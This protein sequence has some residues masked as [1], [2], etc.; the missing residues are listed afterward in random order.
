MKAG[1]IIGGAVLLIAGIALIVFAL[2][3]G[4]TVFHFGTG[5][6]V[7]STYT[8][9]EEYDSILVSTDVTDIVFAKSEDGKTTVV[10][11]EREHAR[12]SVKI[13]NGTLK[14]IREFENDSLPWTGLWN[15]TMKVTV[16]LPGESFESLKISAA[17]G[18][19]TVPDGFAFKSAEI[20]LST[21]DTV[22]NSDVAGTLKI[23]ASTG[24]VSLD[25]VSAGDVSLTVTTGKAVCSDLRAAGDLSVSVSTGKAEL[26]GVRC[27]RN[28][29]STGGTGKIIMK[30]LIAEG[31]ITIERTTGDVR[32]D[33]CD[34]AGITVKTST[35]DVSGELLTPKTFNARSTTGD[36]SVPASQSGGGCEIRTTTGDIGITVS[37][38][39]AE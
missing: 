36:V 37:G 35:G 23:T 9:G 24:D 38:K 13:E 6:E 15:P 5:S 8:P 32:F 27:G 3:S 26:T 31:T 7:T 28:F 17:T 30:D 16:Y 11:S 1:I 20:T 4:G 10:C 14:I 34:A 12:H 29:S 19:M 33:G 25:G 18:D 2:L 39:G 22:F 21:G